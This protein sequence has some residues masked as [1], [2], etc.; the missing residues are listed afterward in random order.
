MKA[1]FSQMYWRRVLLIGVLI[2]TLVFVLN[3]VLLVL[4]NH[5]WSQ[6]D[7]VQTAIQVSSWSTYILLLLLTFGSALWV[8]RTVEKE[9]FLNGVLLGTVVG[10]LICI[11][12]L[13][14]GSPLLRSL[15]A[16]VLNMAAGYLGG[17]LGSRGR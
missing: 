2:V 9:P 14:F 1:Q 8:A 12:S 17:F 10:V 16:L 5:I 3:I 15:V 13:G 6:P 4:T 11:L 7:Q